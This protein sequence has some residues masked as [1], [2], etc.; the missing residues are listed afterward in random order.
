[1]CNDIRLIKKYNSRRLYDAMSSTYISFADL[2]KIISAG[3]D[4][5]EVRNR[6]K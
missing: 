4:V 5:K 2:G 3:Y 1:M 6:K